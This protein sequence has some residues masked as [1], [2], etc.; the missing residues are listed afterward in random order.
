MTEPSTVLSMEPTMGLQKVLTME[1]SMEQMMEPTMVLSM[2]PT[3]D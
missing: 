3:M 2:E 1:R